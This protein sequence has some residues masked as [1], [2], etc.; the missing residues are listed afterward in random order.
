MRPG[1]RLAAPLLAAA[2]LLALLATPTAAET[3]QQEGIRLSFRGSLQPRLLPRARPAPVRISLRA[4]IGGSGGKPLPQLRR[5]SIAINRLGRLDSA[6][7]P[8]CHL[9]QIQPATSA[10]ALAACGDSLV[11]G[12]RFSASVQLP[13]QVPYPSRGRIDAFNGRYHG[14]PAILLHIYGTRPIAASYTL[15]LTVTRGRG[16]FGIVLRTSLAR[17]TPSAGRVTGLSLQLGRSYRFRGRQHSYLSAT[18][19]ARGDTGFA[20]FPL[21]RARLG[22]AERS[23]DVTVERSC[24]VSEPGGG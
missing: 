18:C 2:L 20:S 17:T 16:E 1:R 9:A 10:A 22:F 15:P 7:L 6:G 5:F 21:V 11:G 23:L 13:E 14:R 8:V 3:V 19:P 4:G 24:A 12:G